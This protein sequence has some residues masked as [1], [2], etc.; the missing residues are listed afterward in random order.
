MRSRSNAVVL[1]GFL[2]S[3]LPANASMSV[4]PGLTVH[5]KCH[6]DVA[7]AVRYKA[8]SGSWTTSPFTT[9]RGR[10]Q[11]NGVVYSNNSVFYYYAE[12][13]GGIWSGTHNVRIGQKIYP[14]KAKHLDYDRQRNRYYIG[15]TCNA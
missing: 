10:E 7:L 15:L 4:T 13:N 12:R 1:A 3:S 5:N 8:S 2:L 14:M 11:R 9:I 6:Q